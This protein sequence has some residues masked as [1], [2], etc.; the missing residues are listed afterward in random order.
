MY[1]PCGSCGKC[2]QCFR[3]KYVFGQKTKT[4]P[5]LTEG[6]A[7]CLFLFLIIVFA[8]LL[9]MMAK[10]WWRTLLAAVAA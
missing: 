10:V 8:P 1:Q 4:S 3:N 5:E 2:R 6:Q 7:V 9:I